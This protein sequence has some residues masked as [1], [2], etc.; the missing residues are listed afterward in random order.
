MLTHTLQRLSWR[1]LMSS[2]LFCIVVYLL[3]LLSGQLN[4]LFL[5]SL[6][7]LLWSF[8]AWFFATLDALTCCSDR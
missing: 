6:V 5:S 4:W 7:I 1:A 2:L 8:V 3:H